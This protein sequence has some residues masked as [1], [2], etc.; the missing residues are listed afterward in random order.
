MPV[1]QPSSGASENTLQG[2][3]PSRRGFFFGAATAGVAAAAVTVLP[4]VET[5]V[6]ATEVIR[7]TPERGGGYTESAHVQR[8]YRTTRV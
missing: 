7:P 5:A 8:Y 3:K 1:V 4:R 2:I 6:Q